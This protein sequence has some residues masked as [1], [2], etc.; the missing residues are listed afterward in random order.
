MAMQEELNQFER[1]K[2]WTLV[3]KPEDKQAPRSWYETLS[4][5]LIMN[6]F[7]TGN[8]DNALF[9]KKNRKDILIVQIYLDDIIFGYT[10]DKLCKEFVAMMQV[11]FEMSMVGEL[12]YFLGLQIKQLKDGIFISQSKYIRDMLKKCNMAEVKSIDTPM[13]LSIKM[14]KDKDGKFVD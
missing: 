5:F 8:V 3:L 2:V 14:D 12:N 13:S 7:K 6:D 9:I 11:E 4:N 10:N 1:N